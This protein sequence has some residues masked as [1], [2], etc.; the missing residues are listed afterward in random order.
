MNFT[1]EEYL[2]VRVRMAGKHAS[3]L[4][5]AQRFFS[6]PAGTVDLA[7]AVISIMTGLSRPL[8][9]EARTSLQEVIKQA[10]LRAAF[11]GERHAHAPRSGHSLKL[12]QAVT[13]I[14]K[15]RDRIFDGY[16]VLTTDEA[17]VAF[18]ASLPCVGE[19]L[20]WQIAQAFGIPNTGLSGRLA[21]IAAKLGETPADL[22]ARLAAESGDSAVVVDVVLERGFWTWKFASMVQL[23]RQHAAAVSTQPSASGAP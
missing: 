5:R 6:P 21:K 4:E 9:A 2:A 22:C 1:I 23:K 12:D 14:W 15:T 13:E 10:R 19:K 3:E 16:R 8:Y 7:H 18:L 20:G 17:R 11:G